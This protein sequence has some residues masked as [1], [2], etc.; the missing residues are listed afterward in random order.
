[1]PMLYAYSRPYTSLKSLKLIF[2]KQH[3]I[4][5]DARRTLLVLDITFQVEGL[6]SSSLGGIT[7]D[8]PEF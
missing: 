1:M 8:E 3:R 7:K 2:T 6:K 5:L 4:T